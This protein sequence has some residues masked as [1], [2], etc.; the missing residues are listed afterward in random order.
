MHLCA[1]PRSPAVPLPP[2]WQSRN[3]QAVAWLV[4]LV[5]CIAAALITDY[6]VHD[7]DSRLY[8]EMAADLAAQPVSRWCAP[9]WNGHW[10]RQGLFFEHP[11]GLIWAGAA[12][13]RLH[14]PA[15]QALY[16]VNFVCFF[17][18]LGF[19]YLLGWYL[20]GRLLGWLAVVGWMLTPAFLQYLVRGSQ[21]HPLTCALLLGIT[22]LVMV[23]QPVVATALW[24]LALLAAVFIKGL[25]G[26]ALVAIGF[27]YWA[28]EGRD[29]GRLVPLL[30]GTSLALLGACLFDGWYQ[31]VT[32]V[33]FWQHYVQEQVLYSVGR[34]STWHRKIANLV[35]YV[36]RPMWFAA[37]VVFT[38]V[39]ALV[40]G[41]RGDG[42]ACRGRAWQLGW[43]VASVFVLGFSLADRKADRYIFPMYPMLAL[44]AGSS[45][46]QLRGRVARARERFKG[47]LAVMPYVVMVGLFVGVCVKIYVG[48]YHYHF[49]RWWPGG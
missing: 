30:L 35:Y 24:A 15:A 2:W 36:V 27:A 42:A 33:S 7:A 20:G 31:S 40:R 32:G 9:T 8:G 4:T 18:S 14:V 19:L 37:P 46:L 1:G 43:L 6:R 17:A 45:L 28:M 41:W 34:A 22:T 12:L 38:L 48:T 21:E 3:V 26:L 11:P 23:R 25:A 29:V 16:V 39:V 49:I 10:Q 47:H 5:L 13:V 44:A